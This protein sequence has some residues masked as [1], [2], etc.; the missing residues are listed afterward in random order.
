MDENK[1][2]TYCTNDCTY[3]AD[4]YST[5]C[6]DDCDDDNNIYENDDCLGE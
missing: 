5:Y 1:N 6:T 3:C 2:N 4:D